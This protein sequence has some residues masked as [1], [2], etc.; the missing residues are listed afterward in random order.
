LAVSLCAALGTGRDLSNFDAA[1]RRDTMEY[2]TACLHT[3][4]KLGASVLAGPLYTGGGKCHRLSDEDKKR[5]WNLAVTCLQRLAQTARQ[6]GVQLALEPL[7]RYRS[8]VMNTAA[9]ALQ[10][11][12]D[13]GCG[14]VG[15]HFDT[16]HANIEETDVC[17]ALES[18]LQ[19]EKLFHF[20]ACANNRGAPGMGHLP[21]QQIFLLLKRYGYTGH[22]TMETFAPDAMDAAWYPLAQSEDAL[23]RAGID[24]LK[25]AVG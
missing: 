18:V 19:K 21:W 2:L 14:N 12:R 1:V 22:I 8:S 15:V 25:R 11:V 5:E 3:A 9:Q 13:I 7:H 20:H 6:E 4:G 24:F 16:F 10:M 23:A 17:A